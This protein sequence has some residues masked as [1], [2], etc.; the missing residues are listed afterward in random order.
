MTERREGAGG[1]RADSPAAA[2]DAGRVTDEQLLALAVRLAD[3]AGAAIRAIRARGFD[4]RHKADHSVVT[5]ADR[6]RPRP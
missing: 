2:N 4:V 1:A 3:E 5:E 6:C